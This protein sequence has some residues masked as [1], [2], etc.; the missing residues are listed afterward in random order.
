ML[1][2]AWMSRFPTFS[3]AAACLSFCLAGMLFLTG[4]GQESGM[5]EQPVLGSTTARK[6]A[7][8]LTVEVNRYRVEK[9]S[10]A[11]PRHR[12]LDNLAQGHANYL[13]QNRGSFSLHGRTV[14]HIG[15]EGRSLVAR[16]RLGFDSISEN[17]AST[18]GGPNA[19][20]RVLCRTWVNSKGHEF[21]MR[22]AW[23]HTG[24][25]VAVADDGLVIAVQLFGTLGMR[26]HNQMIDR[27]RG[28]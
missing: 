15:F 26:S 24:A 19:A 27:M 6:I 4:C 21:N 22:A 10:R 1:G 12:G 14:S 5:S 16:E 28:F 17:V 8:D 13:L 7:D 2:F 23:T 3:G 20:A 11:L 18:T 9:G 25:G